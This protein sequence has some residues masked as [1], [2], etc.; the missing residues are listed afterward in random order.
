[1]GAIFAL[2]I[3]G[4]WFTR[5]AKGANH[6][7]GMDA[8]DALRDAARKPYEHGESFDDEPPGR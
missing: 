4:V 8:K 2:L 1:M 5:N 7:A 3:A 6:L